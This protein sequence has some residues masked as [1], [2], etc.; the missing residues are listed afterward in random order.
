MK[1]KLILISIIFIQMAIK[2]A[3]A[4]IP[5][6]VANMQSP[7]SSTFGLFGEYPVNHFTGLPQISIP[8][9]N[10]KDMDIK[11][12]ISLDYHASGVRPDMHPGWVGLNWNLSA[13][14]VISRIVHG[15]YA[16]DY[17]QPEASP[18]EIPNM[19]YYGA[20]WGYFF[21]HNILNTSSWTD[22]A[23]MT[24]IILNGTFQTH[25]Q[26]P[27]DLE[28]D[29]FNFNFLGYS[30][31]FYLSADG[32]WKVKCNKPLK[33]TF[34]NQFIVPPSTV[35]QG[36]YST[37]S[38]F[39]GFTITTEDG[40]QFIFGGSNNAIEYSTGM[41]NQGSQTWTANSWYLTK[42]I[43]AKSNKE[44][45][46]TYE[47]DNYI[48]QM[49]V[50]YS[51]GLRADLPNQNYY[52]VSNTTVD[53][54]FRKSAQLIRP[55]YLKSIQAPNYNVEFNRSTSTELGYGRDVYD[56]YNL[57]IFNFLPYLVNQPGGNVPYPTCLEL[58]QWKE[59]NQI[60]IKT[61]NGTLIKGF[62]L[63]Y[64]NNPNERLMLT[65]VTEL[66]SDLATR[67]PYI[68]SYIQPSTPDKALPSY[69]AE[70][71]D[72]WGF[73]NGQLASYYPFTNYYNTREPNP[74][75]MQVGTLNKIA[76][77]TGGV[78]EFTYE[79]NDFSE[80]V[81]VVRS[82]GL[83]YIGPRTYTGGLR[84]KK[85]SSYDLGFPNSK[86]E[87]EYYYVNNYSSSAYNMT[88]NFISSG[89]LGG[90]IQYYFQGYQIQNYNNPNV[91]FI[92]DG[93]S[94][95]SVLPACINSLG[96]HI[97]YSEVTERLNNG[98]YT[99]YYY[100]NFN[101]GHL[102]DA[103]VNLPQTTTAYSVYSSTSEERGKLLK[104]ETYTANDV[105]VKS[106]EYQYVALNK[107]N[108]FVKALK[109][110][111]I[112]SNYPY[113]EQ[114]Y[115]IEGTA[116]KFYTYSYLLSQ[117]KESVYD[118]AGL[119]PIIN[120]KNYYYENPQHRLVTRSD[121]TDAKGRTLSVVNHYPGEMVAMGQTVPFQEMVNRNIVSPVIEMESQI[122][123]VKQSKQI[124]NFAIDVSSNLILPSLIQS[125]YKTNALE[126]RLAY[127]KYDDSGNA[128]SILKEGSLKTVYI[129]TYNKQY[130][131]AKIENADYAIVESVLG[132]ATA[133]NNFA[134][135]IPANATV[136]SFL[137]PLRSSS[138]LSKARITTFTYQPLAGISSTTNP[139][140][141]NTIFY[142]YNNF[143]QLLNI[144]DQNGNVLKHFDYHYKGQ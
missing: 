31:S 93:F 141:S 51:V 15:D 92:M 128:L 138:Q 4:Q 96:S 33:V 62:N 24:D 36:Q 127:L 7:N 49:Y 124:T 101:N 110:R 6:E 130:P 139:T 97:G 46:F 16:D 10:F 119:N 48:S 18:N 85:I 116:Y 113:P 132:G 23:Y 100:T 74:D 65:S 26:N 20:K 64:N 13:G 71:T 120:I 114:R 39:K 5:G 11:V 78:T 35:Y 131:V 77:P 17:H 42:I 58:L 60:L 47:P 121:S 73:F 53:M 63:G 82:D 144:R 123:G 134:N 54:T 107:G 103:P 29:E 95:Q 112:V 19:S 61:N 98:S 99:K 90:D 55:V 75:Y 118:Q 25:P 136:N 104:S 12:P 21:S 30:G 137:A 87:K 88:G 143:Q 80:K 2:Q 52:S 32:T 9:Y 70:K 129:W 111:A 44:V 115:F 3:K 91:T 57:W 66:G 102:D 59:L 89:V 106:N 34:D 86:I 142:D 126:S 125:Q 79:A 37:Y 43:S 69:L 117:E 135:S 83:W 38:A 108:E 22:M 140:G 109:G 72:H 14:G 122:N 50:S 56:L 81:K 68:L 94:T 105:L 133:I 45:S 76:Y 41:F 1:K 40:T 27:N 67:P 8:L 28:P 84:I